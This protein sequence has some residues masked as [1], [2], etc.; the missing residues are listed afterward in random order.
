[1]KSLESLLLKGHRAT[2]KELAKALGKTVK[3]IRQEIDQLRSAGKQIL[4]SKED[5]TYYLS[6]LPTWFSR[7]T[8]LNLPDEGEIGCVSDT[9]LASNA[10]RLDLLNEIYDDFADSGIT[11]VLHT[12]DVTDGYCEY[13]GHQMNVKV[14]GDAPQA[15]RVIKSYPK[16]E[17]VKTFV[18]SGNHD[19]DSYPRTKA[20]RLSLVVNGVDHEGRHYDGRDDIRYLGHYS[21]YVRIH[22]EVTAHHL[23]TRGS[24]SYSLS[25]KQQKRNENMDN[26]SR[27]DLQLSGHFH[28]YSHIV[29][30]GTH[31][32]ALPG[33]QD[34]TEFFK[35]LGLA[36]SMGYV[37]LRYKIR[38][39]KLVS[40][41]S[42]VKMF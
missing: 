24:Q 6:D 39:N 22:G 18:I 2:E 3:S 7:H 35:R 25:Y 9:H 5:K 10:E 26:D 36:R 40:L 11:T 16:R 15:I 8:D 17:G 13:R 1:M 28:T 20:D 29:A 21:A 30:G 14:Y 23:H 41:S 27:P 12:G 42:E 37:K 32:I 33:L 34:E 38:N 31:F 4:F 19:L